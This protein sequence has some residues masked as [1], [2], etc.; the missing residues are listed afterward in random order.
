MFLSILMPTL[1]EEKAIALLIKKIRT[2]LINNNIKNFEIYIVDGKSN[3]NTL[4]IAKE[5]NIKIIESERGY[6]IQYKTAFKKIKSKYIIT[7]DCDDTYSIDDAIKLLDLLIINKLDFVSGDRLSKIEKI[8]ENSKKNKILPKHLFIA[9]KYLNFWIK[10][11][12]NLDFK[13]SQSGMWVFERN[14]IKKLDLR[15]NGMAFSEELKIEASQ[16]L[17]FKEFSIN[18]KERVGKKKLRTF[19][20]GH[21][22]FFFLFY[23]KI[24]N[25]IKYLK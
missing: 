11:L 20:D 25:T 18:Y 19:I 23:K 12:F 24:I 22:N 16:K 8:K 15:S 21:I 6:G 17:K 10:L 2:S 3:D 5:N 7:M 14:K 1:N 4:K 13:D 9:N